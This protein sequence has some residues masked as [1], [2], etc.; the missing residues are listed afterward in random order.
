MAEGATEGRVLML[1]L[2]KGSLQEA[3]F[4][5]MERAGFKVRAGSRSYIP[6][7]DAYPSSRAGW[8]DVTTER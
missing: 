3:T 2:P 5:L 8:F 1:G 6:E 4:M 7:V